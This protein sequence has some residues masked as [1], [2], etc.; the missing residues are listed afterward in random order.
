MTVPRLPP[1]TQLQRP[2]PGG[3]VI[4]A[5]A[6]P[7]REAIVIP[8]LLLS[9]TLAASVRVRVP[10]GL[11][12]EGPSL[13]GLVLGALLCL[14]VLKAGV[15]VPSRILG[16]DRSTLANANG[17]VILAALLFASGQ[18]CTMLMP[19][20]GLMAVLFGVFYLALLS[21]IATA[22]PDAPRLLRAFLVLF[23]A[24]L[25]LR[26]V[27]LNGLAAPEGSLARRLFTTA[28]QGLTLG[29]LGLEH[30]APATGYAAFLALLL[31]FTALVLLPGRHS[32]WELLGVH[33]DPAYQYDE[34]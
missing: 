16:P 18:V 23:T 26:F 7:A 8:L 6:S 28:L 12:L 10:A 20:G 2:A 11:T 21:S 3:L 9:A 4:G 25:V 13:F 34:P 31:F 29:S 14:L 30:F 32:P 24:G 17:V 1:S 33:H 27:V 15:L 5:G 22:Q 19:E